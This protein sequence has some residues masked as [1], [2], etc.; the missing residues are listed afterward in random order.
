MGREPR[1]G[2]AFCRFAMAFA[3]FASAAPSGLRAEDGIGAGVE[4]LDPA[5]DEASPVEGGEGKPVPPAVFVLP[6]EGR[7]LGGTE[8]P[9][10]ERPLV[11]TE[12]VRQRLRGIDAQIDGVDRRQRLREF[13]LRRRERVSDLP[14]A[15][16]QDGRALRLDLE[17]RNLEFRRD[18]LRQELKTLE[19]R[20]LLDRQRD[21]AATSRPPYRGLR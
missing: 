12:R 4:A 1:Y 14:Q 13:Q 20:R 11:D 6:R 8:A 15:R 21:R 3:I 5:V 9:V 10:R 17:R 16:Q 19:V 7:D 2:A 18:V